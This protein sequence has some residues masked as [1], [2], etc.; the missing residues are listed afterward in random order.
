MWNDVISTVV[1]S[2]LNARSIL[3]LGV[4]GGTIINSI[5]KP[6]PQATITGIE[7]DPVII[8]V[9]EKYFGLKENKLLSIIIDDAV[10]WVTNHD[11]KGKYDL[12][13]IDMYIGALNPRKG[14]TESF[15]V[16]VK[17]LLKNRGTIIYNCDYQIKNINKYLR[18]KKICEQH[19]KIVEEIFS[20]DLNRILLLRG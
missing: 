12:I 18:Y 10:K 4:A 8:Q 2:G 16:K 20:Y 19:F 6:Y 11:S 17:K 7:I 3:L 14:R 1:K 5:R 13:I 9:G 15:L